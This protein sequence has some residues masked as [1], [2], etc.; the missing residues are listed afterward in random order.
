MEG[1]SLFY[2]LDDADAPERHETQYFEVGGNRG[3]YHKG[4]SAVT[5]HTA[6]W[7]AHLPQPPFDED[8][9]E[10]Y[11]PGDWSQARDMAAE[12][13]EELERL[14]RL[15]LI[16]AVK[17]NVLPMDDRLERLNADIAGRPQL[18][19]GNSQLFFSG[20]GRLNESAVISVKNKS[21]S[22]T[23]ELEVPNSGAEGVIIAQGGMF[24]GWSLYGKDGKLKYCYNLLGHK[25]WFVES[26]G[27]IP[28]GA[29]QVRMEFAY[30]GGGIGKGGQA[31]LFIDGEKVGSGR[32]EET[33]AMAFSGDETTDVGRE[34]GSPVSP[35]YGPR[36]NE[37]SGEVSWVQIDLGLDD[38]SHMIAPE[39]RLSFAMARQ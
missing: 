19:R 31:T 4:W 1:T 22:V 2:S 27:S 9:W 21:Y 13:P 35:D 17:F 11:G 29:H 16:E 28:A 34:F 6:S 24:G 33:H 25:R 14:K 39:Q 32:V 5:P 38:H 10:L 23:A 26:E 3:I 30:D 8:I 15:W 20:M 37:F 18:V 36:G 12:M 7:S